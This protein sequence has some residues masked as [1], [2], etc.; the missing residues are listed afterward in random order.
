MT[1]EG[2]TLQEVRDKRAKL[3]AWAREQGKYTCFSEGMEANFKAITITK[4]YAVTNLP[5][6]LNDSLIR[7]CFRKA[8]RRL[9]RLAC[10][11]LRK[12]LPFLKFLRSFT[13]LRNSRQDSG[14]GPFLTPCLPR[15][16]KRR[17]F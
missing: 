10:Y 16:P 5:G 6:N 1:G 13:V 7:R 15:A 8:R 14:I 11:T 3:R 2:K 4:N 9:K 12:T 17:P